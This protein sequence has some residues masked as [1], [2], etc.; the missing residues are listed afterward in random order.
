VKLATELEECITE[1]Q[2]SIMRFSW[3]KDSIKWIFIKK[4]F[5]FIVGNVYRVKRF[6]TGSRN[7]LTDV[8]KWQI[9]FAQAWKWLR[10][11][12]KGFHAAGFDALLKR[13]D[14]CINVVVGYVEK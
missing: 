7:S 11:H 10:Q 12:R 13:W 14:T 6:T 3:A 9:M 2:R 5:L 1:E 8:R 4:C